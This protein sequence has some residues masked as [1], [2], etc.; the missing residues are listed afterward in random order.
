MVEKE[1]DATDKIDYAILQFKDKQRPF[2]TFIMVDADDETLILERFARR[3][4][5]AMKEAGIETE[6]KFYAFSNTSTDQMLGDVREA[7]F[8]Y[9]SKPTKLES[10]DLLR[11]MVPM[12][13]ILDQTDVKTK[14]QNLRNDRLNMSKGSNR[15]EGDD[16]DAADCDHKD[17]SG[18]H[19]E[20]NSIMDAKR[21]VIK[22][23][24]H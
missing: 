17:D 11:H 10:L 21:N 4:K 23:G 24:T 14:R 5:S 1:T 18:K 20:H 9:Y 16:H 7:G 8:V 12:E 13:D 2:Y 22:Q 3:T 15:G 6:C 19:V